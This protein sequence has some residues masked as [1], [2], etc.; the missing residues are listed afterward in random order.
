M[1]KIN[2]E[3]AIKTLPTWAGKSQF[4]YSG[5][6][7][8]GTK[9][10]YGSGFS[11]A[12]KADQYSALLSHFKG[13]TVDIGTIFT[14]PPRGSLGEWL[15]QNVTKVATASYVGPILI[16]EN[17]AVKI[18]GSQIKFIQKLSK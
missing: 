4:K 15:Q 16:S 1:K 12:I 17:Y 2:E 6:V 18:G 14:N 8:Q 7:S 10:T 11:I 5:S 3:H 9:I 13:K